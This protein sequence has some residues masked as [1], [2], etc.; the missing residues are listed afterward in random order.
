[1][2]I[3][4]GGVQFAVPLRVLEVDHGLKVST[5]ISKPAEVPRI[6]ILVVFSVYTFKYLATKQ[7]IWEHRFILLKEKPN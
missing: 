1:M 3:G 7:K 2:T 4:P 6:E 5:K